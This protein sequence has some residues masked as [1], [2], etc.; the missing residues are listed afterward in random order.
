MNVKA[1]I[2]NEDYSS[3]VQTAD[4][5]LEVVSKILGCAVEEIPEEILRDVYTKYTN[6]SITDL[7]NYKKVYARQGKRKIA[8]EPL[9]QEAADASAVDSFG[10]DFGGGGGEPDFGGPEEA[11]AE[12][13]GMEESTYRKR[14]RKLIEQRY[15][16]YN[17]ND[18]MLY[19]ITSKL[20]TI[21]TPNYTAKYFDVSKDLKEDIPKFFRKTRTRRALK[22]EV[23]LRKANRLE[24]VQE[25]MESE[26]DSE[27]E[28][29]ED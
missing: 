11:P 29:L 24:E 14:K 9:T 21:I 22:E 6:L 28:I 27:Y 19:L 13:I 2:A 25:L 7:A 23:A 5:I 17:E 15:K 20:N 26:D 16:H 10:S 4:A 12:D 8:E 3:A 1:G 18:S